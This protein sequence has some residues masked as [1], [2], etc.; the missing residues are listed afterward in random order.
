MLV[1]GLPRAAQG[2]LPTGAGALDRMVRFEEA[3]S[4]VM[5]GLGGP[6]PPGAPT[7][8]SQ[9]ELAAAV[10]EASSTSPAPP[11]TSA[12]NLGAVDAFRAFTQG[13]TLPGAPMSTTGLAM[14]LGSPVRAPPGLGEGAVGDVAG[15]GLGV[16]PPA[17]PPAVASPLPGA[18]GV[19]SGGGVYQ[20]LAF[21][22]RR[23]GLEAAIAC[24][25]RGAARQQAGERCWAALMWL[26][27]ASAPDF[28]TWDEMVQGALRAHGF[29]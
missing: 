21:G 22:A 14:G 20:P 24:V 15:G 13:S 3:G 25:Q 29:C 4:Q 8:D 7:E 5:G 10:L 19:M 26:E 27:M 6:P 11:S 9:R 18:A 16:P 1:Q 23:P 28:E 12:L 17:G 2:G